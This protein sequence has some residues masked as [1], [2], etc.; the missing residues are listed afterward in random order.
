MDLLYRI[1][2]MGGRIIFFLTMRQ[3]ILNGQAVKRQG[4]FVLALTHLSH[5]EPFCAGM[6]MQRRID[7]MTRKEFY[8]YRVIGLLLNALNAFRV[9][10]QG[11]PVSAVRIA[12]DR[13]RKGRVVGICPEGGVKKGTDAAF[14]GGPIKRGCCSVALHTGVPIIPCVMLGTDK[15]NTVGPWLPFRRAR[16]WVAYGEPIHPPAGVKSTRA[17]R[18]QLA[19]KIHA[20]YQQL[21]AQLQ[22]QYGIRD[23]DVP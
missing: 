13:A 1:G 2:R 22:Q 19:E 6:I 12:I 21:Y 16:L 14:R 5:L 23:C 11:I 10:R 18:S 4:G 3:Y 7:W 9:D 8:K 15:L 17:A 20:A